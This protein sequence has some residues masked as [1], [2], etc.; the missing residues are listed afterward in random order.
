MGAEISQGNSATP[1]LTKVSPPTQLSVSANANKISNDVDSGPA[2][3]ENE[4][5]ENKVSG[6]G[7]KVKIL[8][9]EDNEINQSVIKTMLSHPR[10]ELICANNGK[11][12]VEA[13]S[14]QTFDLIL[15][16]IS[17]P[18][19]D[20]VTATKLIRQKEALENRKP[21][22]IICLTAHAMKKDRDAFLKAGMDDYLPKPIEK[23]KL[24]K[25]MRVWL[26]P[27][28]RAA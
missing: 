17:M 21:T 19:M 8:I 27:N 26:H 25:L 24:L 10:L 4:K 3:S 9:V 1:N 14:A 12:A 11:Q 7:K 6:L 13:F 15:M 2:A 5:S 22:P 20:G 28:G 23:S 16:D 18:V